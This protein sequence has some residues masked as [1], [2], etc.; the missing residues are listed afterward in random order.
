M[1]IL[2]NHH[3]CEKFTPVLQR[4]ATAIKPMTPS[5]V[6]DTL[7]LV[8]GQRREKYTEKGKNLPTLKSY[9]LFLSE[10]I[11]EKEKRYTQKYARSY[12]KI[13]LLRGGAMTRMPGVVL[14]PYPRGCRHGAG[15]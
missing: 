15:E 1:P 13:D 7:Q 4:L 5:R 3:Q 10:K 11:S 14:P 6:L 9:H 8:S 2:K 12:P